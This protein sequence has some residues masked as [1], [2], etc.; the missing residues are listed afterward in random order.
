MAAIITK[1]SFMLLVFVLFLAFGTLKLV[2]DDN[3]DL[4]IKENL[5]NQSIRKPFQTAIFVKTL[6]EITPTFDYQLPFTD[7]RI[8]GLNEF[9]Y[10]GFIHMF[11][12]VFII[13]LVSIIL[14]VL[15][16]PKWHQV[17]VLVLFVLIGY[18]IA[19][20]LV[21]ATYNWSAQSIGFTLDEASDFRY[22]YANNFDN[23]ILPMIL[24]GLWG[25]LV[26]GSVIFKRI[27]KN[28]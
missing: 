6:D 19:S 17:W 3:V 23:V 13:Y 27:K 18:I 25:F 16:V 26:I 10:P 11:L 9:P 15:S 2:T 22:A 4:T 12:I 28:G 1:N 14:G 7:K 20:I 5:L 21:L 24:I 8:H